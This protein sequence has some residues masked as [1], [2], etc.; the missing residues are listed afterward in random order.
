MKKEDYYRILK[1]EGYCKNAYEFSNNILRK[2]NSYFSAVK[3]KNKP[4]GISA[5]CS[6]YFFLR[7]H[8]IQN[9]KLSVM[10]DEVE[11]ELKSRRYKV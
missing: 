7:E 5:L 8:K 3:A 10:Y 4:L 6:L 2:A 1:E 9:S 11:H